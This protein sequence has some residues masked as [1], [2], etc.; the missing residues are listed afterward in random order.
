MKKKNQPKLAGVKPLATDVVRIMKTLFNTS[1]K[2]DGGV[3]LMMNN[4]I[5][6][7][8]LRMKNAGQKTLDYHAVNQ[9]I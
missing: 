1:M 3:L 9:K 2:M 4:Q 7:V 5:G 8:S 6:V